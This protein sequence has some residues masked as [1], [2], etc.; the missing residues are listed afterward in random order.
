MQIELLYFGRPSDNLNIMRET[1]SPPAGI[2]TIG[3]LLN[4]LHLRGEIWV[5]ELTESKIRCALNQ[6]FASWNS[7]I[8]DKDEIALFSPI[9]GG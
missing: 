8:K 5:L 6:E 7:K 4:W 2:V 1:V 9:S 3:D